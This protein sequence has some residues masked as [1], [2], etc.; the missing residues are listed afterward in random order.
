[1]GLLGGTDLPFWRPQPST[2]LHCETV[3]S[4]LVDH[5]TCLFTPQLLL[6]P[7][8]LCLPTKGCPG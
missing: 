7:Y 2:S 4:G 6:I 1:M 3:D 5:T 8:S